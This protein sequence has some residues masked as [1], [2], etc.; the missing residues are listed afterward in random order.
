MTSDINPEPV[1]PEA[2]SPSGTVTE[3]EAA[4]D[5]T[6]AAESAP[7]AATAP[8]AEAAA[9]VA[10]AAAI[11]DPEEKKRRRRKAGLLLLL[12]SLLGVLIL[13]TGWY[14]INRK[15]ITEILPPITVEPLPHYAFS[16]Y[17]VTAPTGVAV[18]ADGSRIYATQTEGDPQVIAFDG[19]GKPIASLKPPAAIGGDH[20]PA[21]VA[22][23]PT[24]GDVYATDRPS[25]KIFVYAPDGGYR[26]TFNPGPNLKGWAPL[27]LAFGPK[28]DLFVT[29]VTGAFQ[30]VH[31]FGPDGAFVRTFGKPDEFNFPNGVAVDASG[32][33]YITDSNNGRLFVF[34]PEGNRLAVIKRGAAEGDLALPRG[35]AIDDKDRVY[36]A[37]LSIQGIQ[38]YRA[39]TSADRLPKYIGRFGVE[40]S[41]DGAFEYPNAVAVDGRARIYIA[42][43]RNNRVQVWTY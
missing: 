21:Y 43:W 9:A 26:R 2:T 36:V 7:E 18:N 11:E 5:A 42:D 1:E 31:Q 30:A 4:A 22:V 14:L 17:G 37:D 39:L 40:G 6:A 34:D 16:I 33:V 10:V 28:G 13:F 20:L 27:G 29:S 23:N 3:G 38:V 35:A 32:K 12:A 24:N 25:G 41:E 15:P 8:G 19:S